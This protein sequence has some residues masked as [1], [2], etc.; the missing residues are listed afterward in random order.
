M[1]GLTTEKWINW[2]GQNGEEEAAAVTSDEEEQEFTGC[3]TTDLP[4]SGA[5]STGYNHRVQGSRVGWSGPTKVGCSKGRSCRQA[6]VE[7]T[8]I[9]GGLRWRMQVDPGGGGGGERRPVVEVGRVEGERRR[10]DLGRR[11]RP[12]SLR[13]AAA[14]EQM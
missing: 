7:V 12:G 3:A 11:R 14:M 2:L 1:V 5:G 13:R 8:D 9:K 6:T 10:N 4:R